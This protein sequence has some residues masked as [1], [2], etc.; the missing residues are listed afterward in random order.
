MLKTSKLQNYYHRQENAHYGWDNLWKAYSIDGL[1]W[2][3]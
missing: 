3:A 1:R 2:I